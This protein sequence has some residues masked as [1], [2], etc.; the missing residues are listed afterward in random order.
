MIKLLSRRHSI[1]VH[2]LT[3]VSVA[4]SVAM[5]LYFVGVPIHIA[6]FCGWMAVCIYAGADIWF[7]SIAPHRRF[8]KRNKRVHEML[9][10]PVEERGP[11]HWATICYLLG[12]NQYFLHGD[13]RL[14]EHA[15][16]ELVDRGID[17]ETIDKGR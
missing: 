3:A 11:H 6:E 4:I 7:T 16:K 1:F 5:F 9:K 15:V 2:Y 13:K 8:D 10:I 17:P 14:L 12:L